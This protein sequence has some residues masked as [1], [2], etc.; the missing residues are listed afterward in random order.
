MAMG[1]LPTVPFFPTD[2]VDRYLSL[3]DQIRCVNFFSYFIIQDTFVLF[4]LFFCRRHQPS[5]GVRIRDDEDVVW[6]G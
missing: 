3:S 5:G 6:W 2:D 1:H 4:C